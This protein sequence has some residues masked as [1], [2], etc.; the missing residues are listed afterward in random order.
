MSFKL[1]NEQH[2]EFLSL[3]RGCTGSSESVYVK[4]PHC[5]K[6][7]VTAQIWASTQDIGTFGFLKQEEK[8]MSSVGNIGWYSRV[9]IHAFLSSDDLFQNQLFRKI[10]LGIPS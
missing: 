10:L 8:L 1:L 6:A 7:H 2:L 4:M 5:W 3:K 9:V